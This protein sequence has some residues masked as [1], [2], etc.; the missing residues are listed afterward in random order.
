MERKIVKVGNSMGIIIPSVY[1]NELGFSYGDLVDVDYN[2]ELKTLTIRSKETTQD[3][4][5][6]EQVIKRV[7]DNYLKEKGL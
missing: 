6:L 2:K 5:Y 1:L 4:N 7:V 3:S